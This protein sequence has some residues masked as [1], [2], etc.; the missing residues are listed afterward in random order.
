M[1]QHGG[2]EVLQ[3]AELPTPDAGPGDVLID[4][5]ATALNRVDLLVREGWAGLKVSFPHI[6]GCDIAGVVAFLV[7]EDA[8]FISGCDIRVDGGLVG[9]GRQLMSQG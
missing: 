7:S 9:N 2:L 1:N 4:I 3:P 8:S 6:L 5:K